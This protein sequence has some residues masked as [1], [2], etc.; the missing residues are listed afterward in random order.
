MR[1]GDLGYG[2]GETAMIIML[3]VKDEWR[4]FGIARKL[5]EALEKAY[6]EKDITGNAESQHKYNPKNPTEAELI[7]IYKKLGYEFEPGA[8]KLEFRK[9]R[10]P[11]KSEK[12]P[13]E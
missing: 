5:I 10:N 7:I 12:I 1:L 4:K 8:P 13:V 9:R 11:I 3:E 6:P 2:I